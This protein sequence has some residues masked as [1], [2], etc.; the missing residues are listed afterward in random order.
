MTLTRVIGLGNGFAGDDAVGLQVA[1]AL[2]PLKSD[3]FD[4][5]MPGTPD[6]SM[7]EGLATDDLLILVDACSSG[8]MPGSICELTPE[9]LP[10]EMMRHGSTHGF[11]VQHWLAMTETLHGIRCRV[12]VYAIEIGNC[13]MG[14][15]LSPVVME[16][17]EE[18]VDRI[19]HAFARSSGRNKEAAHA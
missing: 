14:A 3:I 13:E 16:A 1:E 6:E 18:V 19:A 4:V 8:G 5:Q 11:G 15:G 12:L 7:F 9:Q 17:A 10:Y 2:M